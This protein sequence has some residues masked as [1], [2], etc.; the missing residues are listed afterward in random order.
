MIPS[1]F[2]GESFQYDYFFNAQ[3]GL[4]VVS[5]LQLH[6]LRQPKLVKVCASATILV[7]TISLLLRHN[8]LMDIVLGVV[9]GHLAYRLANIHHPFIHNR[10]IT[11][12][13][14]LDKP[15]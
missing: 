9:V 10:I 12:L 8:F 13:L 2:G 6:Q 5:T 4:L 14:N 7:S 1:L 11:P 3:I 15:A